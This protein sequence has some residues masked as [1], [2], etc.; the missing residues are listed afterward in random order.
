LSSLKK[1]VLFD[2]D[3]TLILSGKTPRRAITQAMEKIFGTSGQVDQYPFSGKT[4]LQ[5]IYEVMIGAQIEESEVKAKIDEA[6]R[7]YVQLIRT[8]LRPEEITVL[9]GITN[10]LSSLK[11]DSGIVLG[12]L[13]GNVMEG[14]KIKLSRAGLDTYF[15]N[16][17]GPVG[18]FGSDSMLRDDLPKI[19][20]DR[21]LK[22]FGHHFLGKEVVIIGD[23]PFDVSCGRSL[24]VKSVAVAT[25][26]HTTAELAVHG[27]D[28]L[29]EDFSNTSQALRVIVGA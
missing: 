13:T 2:I 25:G 12:L 11:E 17:D 27:P 18:A 20:V 3:G 19:A 24:G 21:A 16:G 7:Q 9:K 22:R 4:D 8:Y 28:Y 14:A 10:L 1:L 5:I 15:F 6:I 26:W 29:F 23:S